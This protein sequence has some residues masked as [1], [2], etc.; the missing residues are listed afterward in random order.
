MNVLSLF[1]GISCGNLALE[2]AGLVASNY[3]SSEIDKYAINVTQKIIQI[4]YSLVILLISVGV[5][6]YK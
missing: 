1:D 6:C 5:N 3:Y 2:R 4:L